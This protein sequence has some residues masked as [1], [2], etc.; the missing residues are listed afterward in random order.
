M[1]SLHQLVTDPPALT[2]VDV[3]AMWLNE[4]EVTYRALTLLPRTRVVGFEPVEEECAKLNAL[5]RPEHTFLPFAI[6]D[7]AMRTFH[8]TNASMT[9]SLYEPNTEYLRLFVGVE[10]ITRVVRTFPIQTRRL[11]DI[12][13]IDACHYLK[14]DVQGAELDVLRGATRLLRDACFVQAEVE[15]SPM[16]KGQPLFADVDAYMRQQGF[17][18]YNIA[19]AQCRIMRPFPPRTE[20]GR[21]VLGNTNSVALWSE[22]LYIPNLETLHEQPPE[23]LARTAI[24][25]HHVFGAVDV[26]AHFLL[27]HHR[28]TGSDTWGRYIEKLTGKPPPPP[29][30]WM[31]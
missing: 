17:G 3:G 16:Y 31:K 26:A 6:G 9:S 30:P 12:P 25:L 1:F 18:L 29:P 15:F 23:R 20:Q 8:L 11:D 28:L 4:A 10:E 21:R 2:I 27:I 14:L 13:Q 22:A 24:I 5:N 19:P 7:G